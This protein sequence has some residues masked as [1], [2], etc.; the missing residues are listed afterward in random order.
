M[1]LVKFQ[2]CTKS[3]LKASLTSIGLVYAAWC[4]TSALHP[5]CPS[6]SPLPSGFWPKNLES[7]G[8]LYSICRRHFLFSSNRE[9]T[10]LLGKLL[11]ILYYYRILQ[12]NGRLHIFRNMIFLH[13]HILSESHHCPIYYI[14]LSIQQQCVDGFLHP[15]IYAALATLT[16]FFARTKIL[17][18]D[19]AISF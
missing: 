5:Q 14:V 19:Q 18:I 6:S 8:V 12:S 2:L 7:R 13:H 10:F 17:A 4:S 1:G 16:A 3:T 9:W 15:S 11:L